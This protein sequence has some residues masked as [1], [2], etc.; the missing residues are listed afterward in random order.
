MTAAPTKNG[1]LLE[2]ATKGDLDSVKSWIDKGADVNARN[3]RR[4]TPLAAAAAS[5]HTEV[6]KFLVKA[7]ADVDARD[8]EGRTPLIEAA[9]SGH[10]AA[11]E[12][13]IKAGANVNVRPIEGASDAKMALHHALDY[14]LTA[15]ATLLIEKGACITEV[16]G[17]VSVLAQATGRRNPAIVK[18]LLGRGAVIDG[19]TVVF[20]NHSKRVHP[21]PEIRGM[22]ENSIDQAKTA[23]IKKEISGWRKRWWQFWKAGVSGTRA[24]EGAVPST[25]APQ[26]VRAADLA[27]KRCIRC[28]HDLVA[29]KKNEN[30][31]PK[32][33][34]LLRRS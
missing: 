12:V 11:A 33:G 19:H 2:A 13:L 30:V 20:A 17:R 29:H 28:G 5:G 1:K 3:Y 10:A 34:A 23:E 31:C 24:G 14:D 26:R 18:L 7:G 6:V 15:L 27:V 22:L 21:M 25:A 9:A 16:P 32:C 4:S 8:Q